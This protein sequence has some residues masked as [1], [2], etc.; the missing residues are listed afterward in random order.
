MNQIII[1]ILGIIF[2]GVIVLFWV[3]G[4]FDKE[5]AKEAGRDKLEEFNEKRKKEREEN[6]QKI[7]KLLKEKGRLEN[8]DVQRLLNVSDATA[9]RYLNELEK[10]GLVKQVGEVGHAVYYKKL[11]GSIGGRQR[12]SH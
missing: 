6:K 11:N 8:D 2:G 5:V 7:L 12:V 3:R 1:F 4:K 9:E 10:D